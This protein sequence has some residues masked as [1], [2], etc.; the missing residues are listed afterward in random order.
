MGTI[1]VYGEEHKSH[2]VEW[3]QSKG[4]ITKCGSFKINLAIVQ[5]EASATTIPP[6][7]YGSLITKLGKFGGLYIYKE[8]IRILPYGD[9]DFD[10]LDIERNRTKSASY[11]YFSYRR[12]FG[13]INISQKANND[14]SEKA[15]RE[16]FRENQAYRQ[17]QSILKNFFVQIAADFFRTD[18][19]SRT[20][21]EKKEEYQ[22]AHRALQKREQQT[23]A[24]KQRFS[25]SIDQFFD[26]LD[27][28]NI[29]NKALEI[30]EN[31]EKE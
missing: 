8:G 24:R 4:K 17:F 14:L 27:E 20:F 23:R 25:E 26:D 13:V 11:Y 12:V 5:G 29:Q 31:I 28:G 19:V 22:R 10:W 6:Q 7:E 9:N 18:S 21:T 30:A 2:T 15:G 1:N 16:G 3:L